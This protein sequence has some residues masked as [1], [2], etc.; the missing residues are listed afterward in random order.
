MLLGRPCGTLAGMG[1]PAERPRRATHADLQAV[2]SHRVAE[3]LNGVLHVYPRPAPPHV[4]ASSVLGGEL[5]GPFNRGRGGPGGWRIVDEPELHFGPKGQRD[6]LVPDLAGWRLERM[7]KLPRTAHFELAPDWICEVLS[8]STETVDRTEKMPIYVREGVRYAWLVQPAR[9]TLEVFRLGS[10]GLWE[11][12]GAH[13][14]EAVV[15]AEPF[16]AIELDL[17]G[18][19]ADVEGGIS[20]ED[21]PVVHPIRLEVVKPGTPRGTALKKARSRKT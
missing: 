18:L 12:L 9:R 6:V 17:A 3:L 8:P 10:S 5:T 16:D 15:R 2:P 19:W 14:G 4:W 21:E 13:A 20:E 1:L 11:L 7:P